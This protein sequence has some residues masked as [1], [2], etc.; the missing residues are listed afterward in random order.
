MSRRYEFA[1]VQL[2]VSKITIIQ[3]RLRDSGSMPVCV[4]QPGAGWLGTSQGHV[5]R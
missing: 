5:T 1:V 3:A 4:G 2:V